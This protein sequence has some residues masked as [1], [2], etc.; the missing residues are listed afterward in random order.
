LLELIIF[1]KIIETGNLSTNKK[2]R[3]ALVKMIK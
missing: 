1:Q 2:T 3:K